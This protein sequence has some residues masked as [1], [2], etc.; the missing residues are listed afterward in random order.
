[1]LRGCDEATLGELPGH[2]GRMLG[3]PVVERPSAPTLRLLE[4]YALAA[5]TNIA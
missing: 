5:V 2:F 1:M 3:P 4:P